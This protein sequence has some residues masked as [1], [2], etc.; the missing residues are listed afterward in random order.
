MWWV[1]ALDLAADRAAPRPSARRRVWWA[2]ARFV[3]GIL[4][5][6]ASVAGVWMVVNGARQTA[7]VFVASRTIV[8]GSP[9]TSADLRVAE[10][11]LGQVGDGYVSPGALA[12]DAVATRTIEAGEL[13][14][15]AAVGPAS[16][17][18]TTT[19][20]VPS[21]TDVPAAV[22]AGS[23]VELW[24]APQLDRGSYDT[25]RI[26]VPDATVVAVTRDDSMA[27]GASASLELVIPRSDVADALAALSG[28]AA[29]S[30]VPVGGGR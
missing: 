28:G 11:G 9:I 1:T 24:S 13:L 17:V 23:R 2:D 5:I 4:L 19:I 15:A 6:A 18:T 10:V 22:A 16:A 3:I 7:P 26:L 20:V 21:T 30:V 14:P 12:A 8:A 25:P 27:G 29:L